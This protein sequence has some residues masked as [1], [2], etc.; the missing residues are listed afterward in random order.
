MNVLFPVKQTQCT[1]SRGRH[2]ASLPLC[3]S[4]GFKTV[5]FSPPPPL[6]IC[7]TFMWFQFFWY[8]RIP[9]TRLSCATVLHNVSSK[10]Y[11]LLHI[12]NVFAA[13]IVRQAA[14][15][16]PILAFIV[17]SVSH[18]KLREIIFYLTIRSMRTYLYAGN[19]FLPFCVCVQIRGKTWSFIDASLLRP[20]WNST[21]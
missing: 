11:F 17:L 21:P 18:E 15:F 6:S 9:P 3:P 13:G 2:A 1:T 12:W 16:K 8:T 7:T 14:Y 20:Y 10:L 19:Q 5:L 4:I